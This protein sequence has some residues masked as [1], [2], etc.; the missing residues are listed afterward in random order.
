MVK[1]VEGKGEWRIYLEEV[2]MSEKEKKRIPESQRFAQ[3]DM[4][5]WVRREEEKLKKSYE[6]WV[7]A[8]RPVTEGQ[9][10]FIERCTDETLTS[11]DVMEALKRQGKWPPKGE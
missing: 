9:R 11:L 3:E 5:E 8:G 4:P 6:R 7:K 1:V 10:R 2:P